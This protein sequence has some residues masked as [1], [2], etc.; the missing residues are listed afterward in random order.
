MKPDLALSELEREPIVHFGCT[1]TELKR[2]LGRAAALVW[3]TAVGLMVL[4]LPSPALLGLALPSWLG[5]AYAF[6]RHIHKHRAGKPLYYERHRVAVRAPGA[7][8]IRP[9]LTYQA[10]RTRR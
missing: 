2:C 1:W 10:Q 9:G 3:P 4:A 5:V 6:T 7:P 8:F